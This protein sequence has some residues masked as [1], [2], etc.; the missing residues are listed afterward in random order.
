[1]RNRNGNGNRLQQGKM[2][3]DA[4]YYSRYIHCIPVVKRYSISCDKRVWL[5]QKVRVKPMLHAICISFS[6]PLLNRRLYYVRLI[7]LK[8]PRVKRKKY[9]FHF[10]QL[11]TFQRG[12]KFYRRT[13]RLLK[14]LKMYAFFIREI[15]PQT[16]HSVRMGIMQTESRI[17]PIDSR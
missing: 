16:L 13:D 14:Q 10:L 12:E 17:F 4:F 15:L 11:I 3:A 8:R 7:L 2:K 9:I 5:V 1:M 6:S